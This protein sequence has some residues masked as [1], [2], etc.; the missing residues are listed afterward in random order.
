MN[1]LDEVDLEEVKT[2]LYNNLKESG[3]G[4]KLKTF[5]LS[6]DFHV[7][8]ETLLNEARAGKRFTP[9]AKQIF[10]AFQECPY[11]KL[12]VV[13]IGQDPYPQPYVADGISFSCSN[14]NRAE[15][16]LRYMF[17]AIEDNIY[18]DGY[19]WDPDLARWSNQGMLLINC[20]FTTN[21]HKVGAHYE[22]WKPFL[23][24][25]LDHLST[26][27]N[28]LIYVFLGK[29]AQEWADHVS[30]SNFKIFASHPASA[31]YKEQQKWDGENIFADIS[32]LVHKQYNEKIIW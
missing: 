27:N 4:D 18:K 16:S 28:G 3:W 14:T 30:D 1:K 21:I 25:L 26:T 2:K 22:L 11:D 15:A 19:N 12:K 24:F 10:R 5:L 7:V 31:A 8:L 6:N 20:A 23:S 29:K 32:Q 13:I 9:V 17:K